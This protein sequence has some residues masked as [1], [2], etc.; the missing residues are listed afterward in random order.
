MTTQKKTKSKARMKAPAVARK[1]SS[2][3]K[4]AARKRKPKLPEVGPGRPR[5]CETVDEFEFLC[6]EYIAEAKSR[7][8]ERVIHRRAGDEVVQVPSPVPLTV[9]GLCLFLGIGKTTFYRYAEEGHKYQTVAQWFQE[10]CEMDMVERLFDPKQIQ[11]A[12]FLL[13]AKFDY[14]ERKDLHVSGGISDSEFLASLD[15]DDDPEEK[16]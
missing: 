4:A 10:M 15:W 13:Q 3:K 12:K 8:V 9:L 11:A 16:A 5:A 1:K 14:S 2:A 7:T 6:R